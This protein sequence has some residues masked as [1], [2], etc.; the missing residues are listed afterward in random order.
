M[1][2][3]ESLVQ[4]NKESSVPVYLQI[5]NSI[6]AQIRRGMLKPESPLPGSRVLADALN[7]HRKTVV[8]AYD[9]LYAQ[10]WVDSYPRKGI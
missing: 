6:I 1:H 9:E 5:A 7:V 10:S 4:I 3:V 8:A 2:I